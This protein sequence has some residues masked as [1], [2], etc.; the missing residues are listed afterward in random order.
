MAHSGVVFI[1]MQAQM[2]LM[3]TLEDDANAIKKLIRHKSLGD[4]LHTSIA[5]ALKSDYNPLACDTKQ[6]LDSLFFSFESFLERF[7]FSRFRTIEL[8]L[9]SR[10][11]RLSKE[12][13]KNSSVCLTKILVRAYIERSLCV[14]TFFSSV[15]INSWVRNM[16]EVVV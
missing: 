8:K 13:S 7:F 3:K 5:K 9:R 12:N 2:T 6:K 11:I 1:R 4:D 16:R 15:G 14:R 10:L